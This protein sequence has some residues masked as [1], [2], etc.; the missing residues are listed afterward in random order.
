[1]TA[2]PVPGVRQRDRLPTAGI[3]LL[4]VLVAEGEA[5][6]L[7]QL[8]F[9]PAAAGGRGRMRARAEKQAVASNAAAR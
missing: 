9:G 6:A 4:G 7:D 3:G 5:P 2:D 8:G 1:M